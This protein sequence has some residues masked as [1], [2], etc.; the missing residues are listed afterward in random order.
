MDVIVYFNANMKRFWEASR[1]MRFDVITVNVAQD[2]SVCVYFF[3]HLRS[4]FSYQQSVLVFVAVSVARAY[5][6][7]LMHYC[8]N[9]PESGIY[10]WN[11]KF[12]NRDKP[13]STVNA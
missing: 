10:S 12:K 8:N 4:V 9:F 1:Y 13:T 11:T 5:E 7:C 6:W 3:F 2:A